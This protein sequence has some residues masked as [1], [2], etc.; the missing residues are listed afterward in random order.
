IFAD[1][2]AVMNFLSLDEAIARLRDETQPQAR[3]AARRLDE[4]IRSRGLDQAAERKTDY[5]YR[6]DQIPR[7]E[8]EKLTP[9]DQRA[10]AALE[11][12]AGE[13]LAELKDGYK[14]IDKIRLEIDKARN[15]ANRAERHKTAQITDRAA[16]V[17]KIN[18][19]QERDSNLDRERLNDRRILGDV[20]I[21]H[22]L[23]DCAAFDYETARDYGHTFRF[24][25][26]DESLEANRRIS[27]LDVHRRAGARGDR[28]ADERGAGRREDRRAI[29]GQ[30]YEADVRRHSP[31]LEEHGKKLD[32][33]VS[34]LG[35]KA[36]N[37]LD[38]YRHV[39]R[40]AGEVIEKYQ[41]QGE[42]LPMP[43][44]KRED[45]VKAQDEAVKHRFAG[46]TEKLERLR[47]ALAE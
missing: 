27:R 40:F 15:G 16:G 24:S 46:H 42:T 10:F 29:S 35:A 26:R 37:A 45:L 11:A 31:T 36:K 8:L 28:A 30:A 25:I 23:A 6:A 2:A 33:P 41:K 14:T 18:S 19:I 5:Y 9:A 21:T 1:D 3:E 22:A 12:H 44:V 38:S 39:Q 34:E 4:F 20:I 47:V 7:G 43:F 32:T 17:I 13:A